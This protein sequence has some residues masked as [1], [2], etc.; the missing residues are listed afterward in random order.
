MR[1][2]LHVAA[3]LSCI[4][5]VPALSFAQ[6]SIAG[7]VRDTS[8][9]VLPGV[10]VEASSPALIEKARSVVTDDNGQYRIEDLRPGNYSV[11]FSLTGFN[12]LLREGIELSGSFVA[13]VNAE[14]TIGAVQETITVTGAS[15]VV[16]VQSTTRQ[17]VITEELLVNIPTGRTQLTA[18]T[19]IPG[20]NLNNQDVGGTNII[21]VV[22]GT[23][24]IH[25]GS[26]NDQRTMIDGLSVA[27]GEGTGYS[28]NML[29]NVGA[30]QEIAVDYATVT[31]EASTGGV[32]MNLI[33]KQ[34]GNTFSGTIF[35]TGVTSGW[36]G[37]NYDDALKARGLTTPNSL[38]RQYDIN[39]SVGGPVIR[40]KL[41]FFSS[42]RFTETQNYVGNLFRNLNEYKV[43][44]WLYVPDFTRRATNEATE[45]QVSL[46]L[47]WQVNPINKISVSAENHW[48]CQCRITSPTVS[49]ESAL[50]LQFPLDDFTMVSW[51]SPVTNRLLL[52][53]RVG[54]R[55][56]RYAYSPT[57]AGSP[58]FELIP[59]I[60]TAGII[61]GLL[62][63]G[64]GLQVNF[65][66]FQT[67]LGRVLPH[68]L[69]ASYVTGSHSFKAG[70][71]N[72]WVA[73]DSMV[74]DNN[75]H[76]SY[77]F[78]NGVPNQIT[79][80]ATPL[81]RAERQPYDLGVYLQD[82]W[83]IQRLTLNL[84][85][86]FD[87]YNSHAQPGYL[88]PV[89]LAPTRNV[90]FPKT[91]I[92]NWR[93]I[94]PRLGASYDVFGDGKTAIKVG[95]G[96]YVTARGLQESAPGGTGLGD[97]NSPINQTPLIVTRNWIDANGNFKPDCDLTNPFAQGPTQTGDRQTIDTCG[98][99]SDIN[100]GT[101]VR[102]S[103]VDPEV[104]SGWG[105]R[106][107][108]WEFSTSV[109]REVIRRVSL[110][111][112]YFRRLYGNFAVLDNLAVPASG[113]DQFSIVVP[114]DPRLPGGGG[115]T[116]TGLYD[117]N[118]LFSGRIQNQ[119]RLASNYGKQIQHFD[120]FDLTV[121]A[122]PG[123]FTLYGGLSTGKTVNDNCEILAAVPEAGPTS[124]A[125]CHRE[126]LWLTNYKFSGI[127]LVR[128][129][130]VQLSA[131]FQS[132]P[133]PQVQ[134]N[135]NVTSAMAQ[136]LGRNLNF[137]LASVPLFTPGSI[138][139][140]RLNQLDIRVGKI[141]RLGKSQASVNLDLYNAFNSSA[142][143]S[144][145][146]NYLN[147]TPTGWRVPTS[148]VTAR[149]AKVSADFS[150]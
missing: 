123:G 50:S 84:G 22:G 55:R 99:V 114:V 26:A 42:A 37:S 12:S 112:G 124:A 146:N 31:A 33:P 129:V 132:I 127:Y 36:Q 109:Q 121:D 51:T 56:E 144:E 105:R 138:V 5:A 61:P 116:L 100:F 140:D 45:R 81:E 85:A 143:R 142:V 125:T 130:D 62:Y 86:R 92:A 122:R 137:G 2:F 38:K 73:R 76:V 93:D 46:R 104:L 25:G 19:L 90:H 128:R 60:E 1:R 10:T 133:G 3:I 119:L 29:L 135:Y 48:R 102:T 32:R 52:E 64:D 113:Y 77:R 94:V 149:F 118:P 72:T 141:F 9:A 131:A 115:N 70:F 54:L 95:V 110:D 79:Q 35:G 148:I 6:A 34:G 139:G 58:V 59:V 101:G 67:L 15:P 39:P 107:Y 83:T 27:N 75:Y 16:D 134:G 88:G 21:N 78:T 14:L 63:R 91:G 69:S 97:N 111:F 120:G 80:R 117:L 23:L 57:P 89:P 87:Y 11:I 68:T 30:A 4:V 108:Q 28:T 13:A 106:P 145:N 150:F 66:P 49:Q 8:G 82:K 103:L 47:T 20:M 147:A 44:E 71:L 98:V 17:R 65:Q 74:G 126:S 40:D 41:W 53:G 43:E 24:T 18:A 96:K 136:G 7:V